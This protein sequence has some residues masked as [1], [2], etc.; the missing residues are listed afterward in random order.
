M[1]KNISV[2]LIVA[3]LALL[4]LNI[5]SFTESNSAFWMRI[6]G[7][8]AMMILGVISYLKATYR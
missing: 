5:A 1:K 8:I 6:T 3:G 4:I 7:N 2:F